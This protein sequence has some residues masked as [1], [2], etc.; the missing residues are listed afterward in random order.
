[1]TTRSCGECTLCCK[2]MAIEELAKPAG[3]WC[4]HCGPGRGCRIYDERPLECRHFDCLWL[5]DE[6]FGPHWKPSKSKLVLTA[7]EDGLEIRCDPGFPDAWRREPLRG[8]IQN[9]A[10]SGEQHDVTVLVIVGSRMILVT[11]QQEF[12]LGEIRPDE[13]IVREFDDGCMVA[14]TVVKSSDLNDGQSEL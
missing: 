9:L 5:T 10:T 14:A 7:S 12:D 11:S 2:V 8:E 1:M 4:Q 6:R 13:R 3:S